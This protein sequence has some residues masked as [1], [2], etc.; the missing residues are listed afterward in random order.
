MV[1]PRDILGRTYEYCLAMFAE[2]E[3]KKAASSS[4]LPVW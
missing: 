1:T 2:Q 4:R 3:G